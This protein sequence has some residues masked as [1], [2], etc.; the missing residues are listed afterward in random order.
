MRR[1]DLTDTASHEIYE[2]KP[3]YLHL[4]GVAQ[5]WDYIITFTKADPMGAW[6]PGASYSPPPRINVFFGISAD[7]Y[8]AVGGVIDYKVN[9]PLPLVPIK[10]G[11][12]PLEPGAEAEVDASVQELLN[13]V[14]ANVEKYATME[15]EEEV[16][17]A[18][19]EKF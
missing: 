18:A 15:I 11:P 3:W 2:I 12:G 5:L 4:A 17:V 13:D 6:H 9:W 10:I 19:E 16:P 8:P 1:P 14:A 7:V